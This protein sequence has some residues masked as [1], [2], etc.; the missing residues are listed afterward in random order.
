VGDSPDDREAARL[1]GLPF[2]AAAYGYGA[3]GSGPDPG[4]L[5]VIDSLSGLARVLPKEGG[6]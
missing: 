2:V 6:T 5:A 1:A 3:A 4:D